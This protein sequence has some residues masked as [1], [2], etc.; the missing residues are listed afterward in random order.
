[1]YWCGCPPR[2][3]IKREAMLLSCESDIVRS[4]G[5]WSVICLGMRSESLHY[6]LMK[7][8]RGIV[9]YILHRRKE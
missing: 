1:V 5:V 4:A 7:E 6:S 8:L 2:R 9:Q 3:E